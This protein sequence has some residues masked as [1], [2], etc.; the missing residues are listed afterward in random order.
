M[1]G[2]EA[3]YPWLLRANVTA[4]DA[5]HSYFAGFCFET[6]PHYALIT[7]SKRKPIHCLATPTIF[8]IWP[9][10]YWLKEEVWRT[11][12]GVLWTSATALI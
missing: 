3:P 9:T 2:Q 5:F 7:A 4:R 12:I 6:R 8:Q 1:F 10:A 11:W